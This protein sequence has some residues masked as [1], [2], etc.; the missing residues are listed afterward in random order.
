MKVKV[1]RTET[2][3]LVAV[4]VDENGEL[5]PLPRSNPLYIHPESFKVYS[6]PRALDGPIGNNRREE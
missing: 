6:P 4:L 5:R 1:T 3:K 2:V